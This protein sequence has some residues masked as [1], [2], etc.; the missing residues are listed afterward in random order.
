MANITKTDVNTSLE[1]QA[2]T[3]TQ[4]VKKL[5]NDNTIKRKFEEILGKNSAGFTA[6]ILSLVTGSTNFNNSDPDSIMASAMIA[7]TLNLPINPNLGFA[8]I[9]PYNDNKK[10]KIA[11]FQMGYKGYIQLALRTGQY[12]TI[13][14]TE[15][16]E[17]ELVERNRITGELIID[18]GKKSTDKIIGYASY[19]RL[20]NGFEKSMF[21]SVEELES[22]AKKYSKSFNSDYS[23][24]KINTHAM[25]LKT[26][27]KLLLSKYGILSVEMQT[28]IQGDQAAIEVD[29][30]TGEVSYKFVDNDED[31]PGIVNQYENPTYILERIEQIQNEF[32]MKSWEDKHKRDIEAIGGKEG[33]LIQKA[34]A[35]K[36]A[37]FTKKK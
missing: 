4:A 2:V 32:E 16:Y 34:I 17:G 1:K 26:V 7:A 22:H 33:E 11:Q 18:T 5:L 37:S 12:K 28:A 27:L 3:T 15:I 30:T 14:A 21:M 29:R 36:K 13:N 23:N 6:S 35:D 31:E 24:W 25:S 19:F 8:Y 10:G 9:L 20:I